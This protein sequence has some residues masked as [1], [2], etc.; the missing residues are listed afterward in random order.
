MEDTLG[1]SWRRFDPGLGFSFAA[2]FAQ[3]VLAGVVW[4][5]IKTANDALSYAQTQATAATD[6]LSYAQTQATELAATERNRRAADSIATFVG[7]ASNAAALYDNHA[8]TR[9]RAVIT[10]PAEPSYVDFSFNTIGEANQARQAAHAER[11][12]IRA[13][14]SQNSTEEQAAAAFLKHIDEQHARVSRVNGWSMR[15]FDEG[16][17]PPPVG[18][19]PTL[20]YEDPGPLRDRL[21]DLAGALLT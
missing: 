16:Q 5:Q 8:R 1:L 4:W 19:R 20:R 7:Y 18:Q 10:H 21:L 11:F 6:A 17:P 3:L 14:T 13:R 2:A 9:L 12:Q 15:L